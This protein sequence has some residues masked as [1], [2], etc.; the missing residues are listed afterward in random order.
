VGRKAEKKEKKVN[1]DRKR[2]T[3]RENMRRLQR[4]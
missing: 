2:E 1:G 3:A 4:E